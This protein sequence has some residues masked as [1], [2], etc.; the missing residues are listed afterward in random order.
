[1]D[2]QSSLPI[3]FT[4]VGREWILN[5]TGIEPEELQKIYAGPTSCYVKQNNTYEENGNIFAAGTIVGF[6][7][8][9]DYSQLK[10]IQAQVDFPL[11]FIL[12]APQ[13][14]VTSYPILT[15][16]KSNLRKAQKKFTFHQRST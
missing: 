9:D 10:K 7:T 15:I 6:L 12:H 11:E 1:M 8:A 16:Q 5:E 4:V 3:S 2:I 14:N 13:W